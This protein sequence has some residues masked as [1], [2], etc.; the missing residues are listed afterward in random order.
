LGALNLLVFYK[1]AYIN[2]RGF[3]DQN[4]KIL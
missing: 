4:L 1:V 2:L 3:N